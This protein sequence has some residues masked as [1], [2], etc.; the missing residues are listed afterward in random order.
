MKT[1]EAIFYRYLK[2]SVLR[3]R[4]HLHQVRW[5]F[6]KVLEDYFQKVVT[7]E[8]LSFIARELYWHQ[9]GVPQIEILAFDRDLDRV[10]TLACNYDCAMCASKKEHEEHKGELLVYYNQH[11]KILRALPDRCCLA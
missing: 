9:I 8:A 6:L 5:I 4:L 2:Q 7:D 11:Q 1:D 10:L 3:H